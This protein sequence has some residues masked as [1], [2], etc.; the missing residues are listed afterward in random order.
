VIVRDGADL[1]WIVLKNHAT[2]RLDFL[3]LVKCL[4]VTISNGLVSQRPESFRRL[5]FWRIR[6]QKEEMDAIRNA[7]R[8]AGVPSR[9]I[10][11]QDHA[12]LRTST[13]RLRKVS[14]RN[15]EDLNIDGWKKPPV[16]RSRLGTGKAI[17]IQPLIAAL[18]ARDWPLP[19]TC[20]NTPKDWLE[21]DP[22]FIHAPE[23]DVRL[24]IRLLDLL[25]LL[26]QCLLERFP[27]IR[28]GLIMAQARNVQREPQPLQVVP[29]SLQVNLPPV[30][31]SHPASHFASS[32]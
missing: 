19:F 25:Y 30:S 1:R 14:K 15:G 13:N 12:L 5:Q 27:L 6:G 31:F 7:K 16:G 8:L 26:L 23:F 24:W 11:D 20:L 18:D 22:M 29:S 17:D 10:E 21:P 2:L 4:K 28:I 9:L 3:Q 32:P